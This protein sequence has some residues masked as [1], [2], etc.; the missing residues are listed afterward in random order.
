MYEE[1]KKELFETVLKLYQKDMIP[2][3]SGNVSARA[4]NTHFVI[5]PRGIHYDVMSPDDLIVINHDGEIIEGSHQPSS[6]APM[7]LAVYKHLPKT[8]A[9]V[10]THSPYALAFA[11]VGRSIPIVSM[12][13]LD[14]RGPVPVAVYACAGTEALGR[15]AVEA[16]QG[17]PAVK[18]TLL[19]NHGVLTFGNTMFEAYA[20]ACRIEISAMVYFM[21]LQ[22]GKPDA[23]A[24]E[25]IEEIMAVYSPKK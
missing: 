2:L 4:G 24:Q 9:V 16:L 23:L 13:G 15:A 7:H 3:N 6:E 17:Q 10:H 20:T 1:I 21:A 5:T 11:V 25:Q 8:A 14:T 18:G 19:K 12:E 22:I